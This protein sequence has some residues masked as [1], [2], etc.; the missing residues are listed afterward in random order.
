MPQ[1]RRI[2]VVDDEAKFA[3]IVKERLEQTGL[4][5]VSV[6]NRGSEALASARTFR[7]E[8]VLLDL[9]MPDL[10]GGTVASH[11]AKDSELR[12]VPII[13]LSGAITE[14]EA[15]N[16]HGRFADHL[17]ISKPASLRELVGRIRQ[18]FDDH[19]RS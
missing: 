15:N 10:D 2:L 6:E 12:L 13:F 3:Q 16:L 5:E 19:A 18:Y 11:M 14:E 7:P 8:L 4:Y 1:K 9:I 17:L